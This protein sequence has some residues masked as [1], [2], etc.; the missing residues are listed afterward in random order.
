MQKPTQRQDPP[1]TILKILQWTTD[2]FNSHEVDSPRTAAEILLAHVLGVRRLDLYLRYDQP[3]QDEELRLF[4]ETIRRRV[5]REPVAYITGSA[6]FWSLDIAVSPAVLI[7]RPE[8]ECLVET[9]LALVPDAPPQSVFEP[10]TGSGVIA[11]AL[12]TERPLLNVIASDASEAALEIAGRNIRRHALERRIQL[13]NGQWF[14]PLVPERSFFD[15]IVSNPPYIPAGDIPGLQPEVAKFE[16]RTALDGGPDGLAAIRH[17]VESS[18]RYLK[19]GGYLLMEIGFDQG[20][21]V[22]TLVTSGEHYTGF[23]VHQDHSGLDRVVKMR[24]KD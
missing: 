6:E 7:P 2:Y 23:T 3:L 4:K 9:A 13:L 16:P 1:W 11:L 19:P 18:H 20:A 8:T 22:E 24:K 10:G 17:L 5:K 12:A 14:E 15:M 21:A